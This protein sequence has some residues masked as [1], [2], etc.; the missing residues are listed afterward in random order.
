MQNN[1]LLPN[2]NVA[3]L[4]GMSKPQDTKRDIQHGIPENDP[5]FQDSGLKKGLVSIGR[6][7]AHPVTKIVHFPVAHQRT[8]NPSAPHS[9]PQGL[10]I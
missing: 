2:S 9:T 5:H 4:A 7:I 6:K 3:P 8:A 10:F 1:I